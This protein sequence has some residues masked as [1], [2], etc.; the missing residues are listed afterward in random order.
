M[1]YLKNYY[2]GIMHVVYIDGDQISDHIV[3]GLNFGHVLLYGS[4][5]FM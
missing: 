2:S 3:L 4:Q 1:Q 5:L